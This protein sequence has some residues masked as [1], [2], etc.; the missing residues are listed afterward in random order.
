MLG[1][2]FRFRVSNTQNQ[3]VTVTLTYRPYK[4]DSSGAL[5]YGSEVT[6][7]SAVS[8][9]ATTG[10]TNQTGVDNSTALNI[11]A[12]ITVSFTAAAATNGTGAMI[13]TLERSTDGGTT[14]PTAGLGE[15]VG[16]FTLVN[17]DGTSARLVNFRVD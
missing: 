6:A 10:T 11:G 2:N 3:N 8:V 1:R 4:F 14:W 7:I 15:M 5:V 12:E 13:V 17:A 16:G 9:A